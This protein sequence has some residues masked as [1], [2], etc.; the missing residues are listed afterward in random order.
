MNIAV[1][2]GASKGNNPAF[3]K[4][5]YQLGTWIAENGHTLV[6][7]GS[8]TGLMGMLAESVYE[9]G[10]Q[11]IGVEPQC[12]VDQNKVYDHLTK[13][14]ITKDFPER[15][16]KMIELSDVFIA[17][18]GGTGTLEEIS[19]VIAKVGLNDLNAPCI[20]YNLNDYYAPLKELLNQMIEMGF[21]SRERQK[22]IYFPNTLQDVQNIL[23][24]TSTD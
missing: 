22:S 10:G 1:Y 12:F 3:E 2:L 6:Y 9:A 24:N 11:I 14:I 21:S 19:E 23:S 13:L 16:T 18:P 8:K 5:I 4:A 20:L 15:K 7:G 17:F